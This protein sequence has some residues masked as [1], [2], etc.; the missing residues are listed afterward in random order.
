MVDTSYKQ[1][2]PPWVTVVAFSYATIYMDKFV[3]AYINPEIK[4]NCLFYAR[5]IGDIFII[6]TGRK[7]QVDNFLTTL[8]MMHK[9]IK[10]DHKKSTYSIALLDTL[11]YI[12]NCVLFYQSGVSSK[13]QLCRYCLW[14]HYM[15]AN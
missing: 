9:L 15:D 5:Y 11:I 14:M 1:E 10:F 12:E 13:Q 3:N 2:D 4:N 7:A 6:Y 8:N